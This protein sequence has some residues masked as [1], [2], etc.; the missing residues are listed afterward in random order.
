MI[1]KVREKGFAAIVSFVV[2]FSVIY[3]LFLAGSPV[4]ERKR[5]LDARRTEDLQQIAAAID[6]FHSRTGELPASLGEL[7]KT[8]DA[9]CCI[10]DPETG[11]V[12]S[13]EITGENRFRL[14][15]EFSAPSVAEAGTFWE[16]PAGRKC[17]MLDAKTAGSR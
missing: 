5:K 11:N 10:T 1:R 6:L 14:C 2:A 12:Y 16:H 13:Y 8:G 4:Q 7:I 15:A 17:F 9:S 3:G